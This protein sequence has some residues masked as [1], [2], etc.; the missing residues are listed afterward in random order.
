MNQLGIDPEA[1]GE[2]E[3]SGYKEAAFRSMWSVIFLLAV[4]H[5]GRGKWSFTGG[6][7]A[8]WILAGIVQREFY[9]TIGH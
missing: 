6:F 1:E 7:P 3:G 2:P 9:H 5:L 8:G 4:G